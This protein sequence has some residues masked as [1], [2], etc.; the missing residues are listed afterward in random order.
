MKKFG[1]TLLA[2]IGFCGMLNADEE[3]NI[4]ARDGFLYGS[5]GLTT[6]GAL[7]PVFGIGL[8][9]QTGHNGLDANFTDNAQKLK[10]T[11]SYLFYGKPNLRSQYYGGLGVGVEEFFDNWDPTYTTASP[12]V[13]V[14][15]QFGKHFFQAQVTPFRIG[16]TTSDI[17]FNEDLF[18]NGSFNWTPTLVVSY[19]FGF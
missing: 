2:L 3:A 10:A 4:Y 15:K 16:Q 5:I 19:G 14:G 6:P 1:I 17:Q 8:R 18:K 9:S 13:L 11:L 12:E 7:F